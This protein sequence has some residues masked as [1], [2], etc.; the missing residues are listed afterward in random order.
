MKFKCD[1]CKKNFKIITRENICYYCFTAKHGRSPD[2]E[3]EYGNKFTN[4]STSK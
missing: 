1:I 4:K 3:K 2:K